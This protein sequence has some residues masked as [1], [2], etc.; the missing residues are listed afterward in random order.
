MLPTLDQM[1][2]GF[3]INGQQLN[4]KRIKSVLEDNKKL[5]RANRFLRNGWT[6]R[7]EGIGRGVANIPIDIAINPDSPFK[8][9]FDSSMDAHERK[10]AMLAFHKKTDYVFLIVDKI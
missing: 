2:K 5:R 8:E 6:E 4:G 3:G 10:K 1:C 7:R 9:Y